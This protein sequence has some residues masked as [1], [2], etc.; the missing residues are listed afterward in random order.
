MST[1]RNAR[2]SLESKYG[3]GCMF[4]KLMYKVR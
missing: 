3:K 4:K 1:N 2:L